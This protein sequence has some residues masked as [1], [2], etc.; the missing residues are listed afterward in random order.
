MADSDPIS[1]GTST[2]KRRKTANG[3][4]AVSQGYDSQNDSGD[5]LFETVATLPLPQSREPQIT[6]QH[7]RLQVSSPR[8]SHITQ[9][10]QIM[11]TLVAHRIAS[12]SFSVPARAASPSPSVQ[13]A[14]SSPAHARSSPAPQRAPVANMKG[15][16]IAMRMAPPGTMFRAPFAV[17]AQVSTKQSTQEVFSDD[18]PVHHSDSSDD[19]VQVIGSNIQ[20]T[21]FT[22]GLSRVQ[23]SPINSVER[24]KNIT[25]QFAFEKPA[26]QTRYADDMANAYGNSRRARPLESQTGPARAQPVTDLELDDIP[27]YELRSKVQKMALIY[28]HKKI[29]TLYDALVKKRGNF[30]DAL[31]YIVELEEKDE[32]QAAIDLTNSDD[33][34]GVAKLKKP[35]A[36]SVRKPL[37]KQQVKAPNR[38]IHDKWSST[39]A[40]Q[41]PVTKPVII[42]SSPATPPKPRRRL[43]QGRK[44]P[45]SPVLAA[46]APIVIDS[47]SD[48]GVGSEEEIVGD[49]GSLLN[50]FNTCS[51]QELA[52][53]SNQPGHVANIIISKR[54]FSNLDEIRTVSDSPTTTKSGKKSAKKPIG[55][56][57]VDFCEDMWTGYE[58]IDQ[59]VSR[60]EAL[61]KP[62]AEAIQ[63]WGFDG[64]VRDG[65]MQLTSFEDAH[66][67]GIETPVSSHPQAKAKGTK[68]IKQPEIMSK[69]LTMKDYQLVGLNWLNLLWEK[70][71]SCILADDMGLGKTCQVISFLSHLY[72]TNIR[73]PHLVIV[74]GST[75]ENWL[76]EFQKFSPTL[77]VEPY[78][79]LQADRA[80]QRARIE[81]EIQDINVIVTTYDTATK[82]EDASF[83]RH[84]EPVVCVYDEG[85]ALKSSGTK[86]YTQLMRI[87]AQFRLLLTGT[88]L[89][90]NLQELASLLAFIMPNLFKE[91][92]DDLALIFKHKAKTTDADHAAL[93]SAQRIARARSMMTPFILRR[94]KHQVLKHLPA[95][96]CRV[97]YC[98]LLPSQKRVYDEQS[99][100]ATQVLLD[101]AAGKVNAKASNNHMMALRK[102]AIHPLLFRRIYTDD[103]L[104]KMTKACMKE[105]EF[106]DR[107]ADYVYEDMEVM[108]DFEL[109]AFCERYPDTM[110]KFAL[111]N[112]EWMDSGKVQA[113]AALLQKHKANGDRT[114]VFSQFTAVMNILEAVLETLDI[115]YF[116]LDGQTPIPTRQD[117]LDEF[118][119]DSSI[120]VFMLSTKAG[121]SGINLACANKVIIFDSSFNPQDDVQAENRAHRVGQTR[122][123]EVVRLVTKGTIEEQIH[124]LGTSKLALDDRVAGEGVSA[125]DEKKAEG[126][127]LAMV[128]KMLLEGMK[129][130]DKDTVADETERSTGSG[131]MKTDFLNGLKRAG[132]DVSTVE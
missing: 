95:K 56:R 82:L 116:R 53:L 26:L 18:L 21:A 32:K 42:P 16:G 126:D 123:V 43:V 75:L 67:S 90:N 80:E 108:T 131:D 37:A 39:Q 23:E 77:R 100:V 33:E 122:E 113:L 68:F 54:P 3:Y 91:R 46:P 63:A 83:L 55:D 87:P 129:T 20:P 120:P 92:K 103:L 84:L 1:S 66:D 62:I 105:A 8:P 28:A 96:T 51:A 58:A 19:E 70:K 13:V 59:L 118:Y 81:D 5:E 85:H 125:E 2:P 47:A 94:K 110:A 97:E 93:L 12:P 57:I 48:S 45:P 9:P 15:G 109:N 71:L 73:G 114:L 72:E 127:G 99:A 52:D 117:M 69:D 4:T 112:D 101:R 14:A 130:E 64:A 30:D 74:P 34:L 104:R 78:Y 102:A 61:G 11:S 106:A 115:K 49:E 27:D 65:E 121:G 29:R 86:R 60:C 79:G 50:F 25:S 41:K 6:S 36:P 35:A 17:Q 31:A 22:S 128:E 88:P 124:A 7:H 119:K 76:R 44:A 98:D 89:Q 24:F 40:T 38:S 10:T 107:N 111:E 132:L